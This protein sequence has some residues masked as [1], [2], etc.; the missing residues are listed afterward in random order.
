MFGMRQV[1]EVGPMSGKSNVIYWLESRGLEASDERVA[2]I[3]D[4]AKSAS[5]VLAEA[6]VMALV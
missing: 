2:R 5:G 6:E 3:F 4:K 1:I